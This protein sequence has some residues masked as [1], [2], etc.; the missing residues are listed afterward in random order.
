MNERLKQYFDSLFEDAPDTKEMSELKEEIFLNTLDRYND[1]LSQGKS[2]DA[3]FTQAVARI[4][5]I[6]ELISLCNIDTDR[7]NYY[8]EETLNEN[9][10][11]RNT[12]LITASVIYILSALIPIALYGTNVMFAIIMII[13]SIFGIAIASGLC[14]YSI[15]LKI[16]P[17]TFSRVIDSKKTDNGEEYSVEDF[18]KK[19]RFNNIVLS[20][21]ISLF[22]ISPVPF[23][24]SAYLHEKSQPGAGTVMINGNVIAIITAIIFCTAVAAEMFYKVNK[25]DIRRFSSS[26]M[27]EDF[28]TWNRIKNKVSGFIRI[29]DVIFINRFHFRDIIF[30]LRVVGSFFLWVTCQTDTNV[31]HAEIA[32]I[33]IGVVIDDS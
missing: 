12:L 3:S 25:L 8:S 5:N 9:N 24:F 26:D 15:N 32:I 13:I 6:E 30:G 23:F 28:K 21:G 33:D 22:I 16:D 20:V 10:K 4:G 1:L 19:R 27:V 7:N 31:I 17:E 29:F 11:K 2:K 18:E 14:I